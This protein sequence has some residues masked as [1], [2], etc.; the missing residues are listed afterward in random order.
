MCD[1]VGPERGE[2]RAHR[3]SREKRQI[4]LDLFSTE[5]HRRVPLGW[6]CEW[7]SQSRLK[8]KQLY[9]NE[10]FSQPDRTA[11]F[12]GR[13]MTDWRLCASAASRAKQRNTGLFRHRRRANRLPRPT[14]PRLNRKRNT[15][16]LSG[17]RFGSAS[18][19]WQPAGKRGGGALPAFGP[20]YFRYCLAPF[21]S[22]K[23]QRR[24][25]RLA[26][27]FEGFITASCWRTDGDE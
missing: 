22:C 7:N 13:Q 23:I 17:E 20:H 2:K 10:G 3:E 18:R 9:M 16:D 19:H 15:A 25:R 8:A 21:S 24:A 5:T 11:F 12:P 6:S 26:E 14:R 4:P 1:C 27:S